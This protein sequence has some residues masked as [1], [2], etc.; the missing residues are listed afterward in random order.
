MSFAPPP[1]F[2]KLPADQYLEFHKR[3]YVFLLDKVHAILNGEA[4][5]SWRFLDVGPAFQTHLLR[6]AFPNAK[7]DTAGFIDNRF[8]ARAGEAHFQTDLNAEDQPEIGGY[9]LIIMAEVLEHLYA[10]P[11]LVLRR[12]GRW[13]KPGGSILLQTPN[14]VSLGKRKQLLAGHSPFEIIRDN[15]TNPGHFCEYT[16]E[17]LN[18]IASSAGFEMTSVWLTNYFG[19]GGFK[20]QIYDFLC[21]VLPGNLQDGITAVLRKKQFTDS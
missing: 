4:S 21:Q 13:L 9:D 16:V 7:V 3:R 5:A 20:N 12:V 11:T 6:E 14:P 1:D 17:D 10:A 19:P 15:P 2:S 18:F 8:P